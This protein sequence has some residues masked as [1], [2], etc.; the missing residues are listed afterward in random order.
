LLTVLSGLPFTIAEDIDAGAVHEQ[1]ERTIRTAV[2]DL[3]RQRLL[4]AAHR[5]EF[6]NSPIQTRQAQE[7]DVANFVF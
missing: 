6:G 2:R 3:D 4:P 1:I 5:K 7:A